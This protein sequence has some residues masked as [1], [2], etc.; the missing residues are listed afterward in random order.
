VSEGRERTGVGAA[1]RAHIRSNVVGYVALF[2][3]AVAGT[4]QALPGTSTVDSG[5]II[6]MEVKRPDLGPDSVV[7]SKIAPGAVGGSQLNPEAFAAG[8]IAP[9]SNG[10]GIANDA[11]QGIEV[12]ANTLTGADVDEHSLGLGSTYAER[13]NSMQL[14]TSFQTVLSRSVTTTAPVQLS[15]VATAN[16][17]P[18][19]VLDGDYGA[20][21]LIEVEGLFRSPEYR[22]EL[23]EL[24]FGSLSLTF[25]RTVFPGS[26]TVALRC[27]RF[28]SS[29]SFVIDAGLTVLALPLA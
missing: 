26:H 8:D 10:Y 6:N 16:L 2:C 7:A 17:A 24:D 18:D 3:F 19:A 9:Q 11:V 28:G 14:G 27:R 21:C 25:G 1:I 23:D 13:T 22:Q 29:N 4:A 15:A 5:D 12:S 20:E